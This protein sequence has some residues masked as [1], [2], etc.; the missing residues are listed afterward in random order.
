VVLAGTRRP[1]AVELLLGELLVGSLWT[2][3]LLSVMVVVLLVLVMPQS[4][5]LLLHHVRALPSW[6]TIGQV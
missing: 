5:L 4:A 6:V 2:I 1:T 3:L